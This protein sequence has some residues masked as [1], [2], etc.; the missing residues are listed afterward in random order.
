MSVSFC[1]LNII[2]SKDKHPLGKKEIN[3]LF[4]SRSFPVVPANS[5]PSL[6]DFLS[7]S[8]TFTLFR[9]NSRS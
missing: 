4:L 3:V 2:S 7:L 5:V 8:L 6:V 9:V 1:F